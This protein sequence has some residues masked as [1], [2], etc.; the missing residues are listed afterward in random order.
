MSE[1]NKS[2]VRRWIED[3]MN[4]RELAIIDELFA[5]D[6]ANPSPALAL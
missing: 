6:Y 1:E 3:G 2:I 4:G 5:P